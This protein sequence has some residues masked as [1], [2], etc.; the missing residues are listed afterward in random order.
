MFGVD[1]MSNTISR[2]YRG[3]I[4]PK[5]LLGN[6]NVEMRRTEILIEKNF[7]KL[8]ENL[9]EDAK[10]ILEKYEQCIDE[11]IALIGEQA[12]Y[13]GFCLGTRILSE[14]VGGAESIL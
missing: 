8:K 10:A 6:G 12:F 9:N 13:D 7:N 2:L 1:N 14:A 11:Y 3:Q 4:E 5:N